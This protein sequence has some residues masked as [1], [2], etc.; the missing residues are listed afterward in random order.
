[1]DKTKSSSPILL[2]G[3]QEPSEE[4]FYGFHPPRAVPWR[5]TAWFFKTRFPEDFKSPVGDWL[6]HKQSMASQAG[7]NLRHIRDRDLS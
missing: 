2:H 4:L 5:A 7:T 6:E 3:D 1:M